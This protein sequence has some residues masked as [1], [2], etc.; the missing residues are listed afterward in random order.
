MPVKQL[1]I[2]FNQL[3]PTL[4]GCVFPILNMVSPKKEKGCFRFVDAALLR[5]F[6]FCFFLPS[7]ILT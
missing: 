7:L 3:S 5:C 1:K 6:T 2:L 4:F